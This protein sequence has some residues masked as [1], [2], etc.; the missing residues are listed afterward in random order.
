MLI[1]EILM[2][3][4]Q[5]FDLEGIAKDINGTQSHD[6]IIDIVG[7]HFP[8]ASIQVVR[9]PD[10]KEGELSISAHY[11]PDFDEE[12]DIAIFIKILFS[13]EGPASFTWSK[14]SKKYFLNKLKD[15]LKHEVL[16][17][18][19]HRDRNFHPGSDGYISDK[20]TE[21]EYMSRPD[22]IEAYAMNIGD[23]FI[24]KVGKDGAVDLLRMA[25]KTAQFKNKVG[26]FLSPD[27]LAY[28]ALFNW[29]PNHS[30]IK[31]LLK[32]IYQH[33]QEQ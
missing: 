28:F 16:H 32:K 30:V 27:L 9:T 18:K 17:M 31:R 12:G 15:A 3:D 13:E 2:P 33:I 24:R 29:D 19:Q 7:N 11:E 6:D 8:I 26:Q 20:G 5:E 4:G 21:L 23:E 22:E 14:N 25:K 10:L 1:K